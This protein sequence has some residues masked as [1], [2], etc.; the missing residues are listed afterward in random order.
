MKFTKYHGLGNDFILINSIDSPLRV[1]I[2]SKERIKLLCQRKYGIGADGIISL[3]PSTK[4]DFAMKISNADGSEAELSGNG[5]RCLALFI[6]EKGLTAKKEFDIETAGGIT[7]AEITAENMVKIQMP[8]PTFDSRQIPM[9]GPGECIDCEYFIAGEKFRITAL[10]L[11]NPHCVIFR[12]SNPQ[13]VEKWGAEI[14]NSTIF[15][16]SVNIEFV[17]ILDDDAIS[18]IVMERGVGIT[19]ACGSG[20]CASVIAGIK[21]GRLKFNRNITVKQIGGVLTVKVTD[22]FKQVTLEGEAVKVYEG[23]FSMKSF[24]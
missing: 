24:H 11:G 21:T 3:I 16:Q 23:E 4:A 8:E 7:H 13:Q 22:D 5:L 18:V 10:S 12:S 2:L 19:N 6:V 14:E 15:R 20:A 17:E 9:S 1:N